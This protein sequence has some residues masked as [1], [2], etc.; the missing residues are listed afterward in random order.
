MIALVMVGKFHGSGTMD[1]R[2]VE[3]L[4]RGLCSH[5]EAREH[6]SGAWRELSSTAL[7]T[8]SH[9]R[10][11]RLGHGSTWQVPKAR[12]SLAYLRNKQLTSVAGMARARE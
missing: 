1:W 9:P 2:P 6:A 5:G 10:E 11:G 12:T 3:V 8:R 7:E 4:S